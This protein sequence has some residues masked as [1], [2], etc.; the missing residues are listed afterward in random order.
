MRGDPSDVDAFVGAVWARMRPKVAARLAQLEAAV[1][2]AREGGLRGR[3]RRD[4]EAEAHR[5]A[6]S[7]GTYGFPEASAAAAEAERLLE[8]ESDVDPDALSTAIARLRSSL[9]LD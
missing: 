8:G 9:D 4:A 2:T 6:G 1:V 7:L 5:L 3:A